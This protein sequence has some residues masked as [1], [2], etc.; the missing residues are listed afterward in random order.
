MYVCAPG[1]EVGASGPYTPPATLVLLLWRVK[2]VA[3]L[4]CVCVHAG[5][6]VCMDV[7]ICKYMQHVW[8]C[9]GKHVSK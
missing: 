6:H 1:L 3:M 2:L 8:K 9:V 4:L 5:M 7:S